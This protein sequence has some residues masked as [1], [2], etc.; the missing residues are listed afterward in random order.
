MADAGEFEQFVIRTEPGLRRA[1]SG[2]MARDAVGDALAEAFAHA[3]QHQDR[4]TRMEHPVGYLFRVARSKTRTRKQGFLPWTSADELPDVEPGLVSALASLSRGGVPCGLARARLR[5]DVS[6]DCR[7]APHL[8]FHRRVPRQS[9][10]GTSARAAR[11]CG[12]WVRSKTSWNGSP[13]IVRHRSLPSRR[14]QATSS[15]CVGA[16]TRRAPVVVAIAACVAVALV[17]GGTL[18]LADKDNRPSVHAPVGTPTTAA[19][20]G[21][22]GGCAGKAYVINQD[23]ATV[24]VITTATGAVS[25]PIT[26]GL[27]NPGGVA[28]TP[29]G[30]QVYVTNPDYR[31]SVITTATG[32]V[33]APITTGIGPLGVAITPDSKH[34]YVVNASAGTVSV[35]T[36]ATGAVSAPIPVRVGSF[37][38]A[39]TPDGVHAYVTNR[40][41]GTVS[42]IT[43]AT[44]AVSA[45]ITVGTNPTGVAI[46]PDGKHVYVSNQGDGTVSVIT[47]ATGAVSRPITIGTGAGGV[48]ITPD[49][50]HAYVT[51]LAH[52]TVSVIT[53][54]TGAVSRPITVGT[55]PTS[56]AFTPDGKHAYV[57]NRGNV[58][59][60]ADGTVSVITTAT[61]AVSATIPVGRGP[62]G[63]SICPARNTH[64]S[65]R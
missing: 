49:G 40:E 31:V 44:G 6:R 27:N 16:R 35:I 50:K 60:P 23:D 14:R 34:A 18:L 8:A 46:T 43:T 22:A 20:A 17:I 54:A 2:C 36:T 1:L 59:D 15:W 52:G 41:D 63:V 24:S 62:V 61:G 13:P 12:Q 64:T 32:A 26:T 33:S 37:G 65:G 56:V 47:T 28:I 45:P 21:T 30:K 51:N 3:W 10:A 29:D 7:S 9:G 11:S 57:T 5:L 25:P 42:V 38:I 19:G 58:A 4:I 53:T 48:A 55:S 39:I